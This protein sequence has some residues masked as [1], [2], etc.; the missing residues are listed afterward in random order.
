MGIVFKNEVRVTGGL[1]V[2][3]PRHCQL[4]SIYQ[5]FDDNGAVLVNYI[6]ATFT[7]PQCWSVPLLI[8][9]RGG[10]ASVLLI[11]DSLT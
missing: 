5:I 7:A 8:N 1:G 2:A 9:G 4:Y 11:F 10:R 6:T 3:L